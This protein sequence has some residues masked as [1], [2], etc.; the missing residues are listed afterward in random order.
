[1]PICCAGL[2]DYKPV[3]KPMDPPSLSYSP[4]D[5]AARTDAIRQAMLSSSRRIRQADFTAIGV[6][7]LSGLFD[8]YDRHFFGGWLRRTLAE[9]AAGPVTFRLS[10]AMTGAGG[11][12]IRIRMTRPDGQHDRY[13][14][15]VAARLL[16]LTFGR[17]D[18][19][20]T[21][22]GLPCPDRLAALQRIMEHEIMHLVE[23][24]LWGNSSCSG[25]R[26]KSLA[27]RI[28]GH[29]ASVHDLVTPAEHAAGCHG[30]RAGDTVEFEYG[31]RRYTG[32]VNRINRRA[33]VLVES[34]DGRLYSD[35][36]RYVRFYVP[37]TMLRAVRRAGP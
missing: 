29:T 5:V 30:I 37:L 13:Q 15:A 28:F 14:I 16:F 8:L 1:M 10:S 32:R 12:T 25:A 17:P 11:K 35:G 26:F 9:R 23:H 36:R 3:A 20:V 6:E 31:S 4:Q 2:V 33:S 27:R 19:P 24:L 7:D 34:P 22:C 18:R 21:V